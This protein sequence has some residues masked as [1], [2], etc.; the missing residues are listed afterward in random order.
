MLKR[1]SIV[2]ACAAL[3][4]TLVGPVAASEPTY[5]QGDA[6]AALHTY[7]ATLQKLQD[8][9][10]IR[11][12]Q[13]FFGST[14]YCADDWHIIA[15]ALYA[16]AGELPDGTVFTNQSAIDFL[17]ANEMRFYLDGAFVET[18]RGP[19][20]AVMSPESRDYWTATFTEGSG[21]GTVV[22]QVWAFQQGRVFAP[23][24]LSVGRHRLTVTVDNP[25]YPRETLTLR[26]TVRA[27]DAKEC[28]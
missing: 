16:F 26:F 11:P 24:D 8:G 27:S 23:A 1:V 4:L 20:L 18:T 13:D 19:V 6:V 21:P 9:L 5:D 15:L 28:S 25:Y 22:K 17:N 14:V 3:A 2:L 7:P 10:D 12:F